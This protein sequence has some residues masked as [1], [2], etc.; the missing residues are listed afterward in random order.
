MQVRAASV[1]LP[2]PRDEAF[3]F[4]A[5]LENLPRWATEFI[6]GEFEM[7]DDH[8]VAETQFGTMTMRLRADPA[9]GVIDHVDQLPSGEEAF[10][11]TRVLP[12]PGDP[13][14]SLFVFTAIQGPGQSEEAFERDLASL[15]VEL[16]GLA[17]LLDAASASG[18]SRT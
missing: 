5:D 9:T 14:R 3:A 12:L 6:T 1:V 17:R 11:P 13:D 10:F 7:H 16:S 4:L 15:H 8:A 18:P 2:V